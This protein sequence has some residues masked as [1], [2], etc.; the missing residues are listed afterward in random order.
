MHF[1]P[2][3][4]DA[5]ITQ[6]SGAAQRSELDSLCKP[7]RSFI[8][9]IPNAKSYLE[10]AL[11]SVASDGG[12]SGSSADMEDVEVDEDE[13]DSGVRVRG[14]RGGVSGRGG[15]SET[16]KRVF[17]KKIIA[18]RGGKQTNIVVREFWAKCKGTVSRY[19]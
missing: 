3:L 15:V 16:D 18:L 5:L 13:Y 9:A 4:A 1:S 11:S 17:L 6:I 14:S 19:E 7:L 12:S 2:V 8:F 10:D